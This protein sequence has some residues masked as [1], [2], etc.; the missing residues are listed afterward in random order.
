MKPR[1]PFVVRIANFSRSIRTLV[2]NEIV[3]TAIPTPQ[4]ICIAEL[5]GFTQERHSSEVQA[6]PDKTELKRQ[7]A[8]PSPTTDRERVGLGAVLSTEILSPDQ[9]SN[10][11]VINREELDDVDLGHLPI[12]LSRRVRRL[13]SK[14]TSMW[15]GHL[16]TIRLQNIK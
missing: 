2:K 8:T 4:S 14:Y 3:G 7:E 6:K 9:K 16:G 11:G 13:L 12:L 1:N 10:L 15:K 5:A